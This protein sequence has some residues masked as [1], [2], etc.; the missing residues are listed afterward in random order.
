MK[1]TRREVLGSAGAMLVAPYF[2]FDARAAEA[3]RGGSLV[4]VSTQS[5]RHLKPAVQSGAATGV[6]G[7]QIFAS[8]LLFDADWKPHPYLAESWKAAEDGLSLT[9]NLVK[10]AKFHDGKPVTSDDV[11]FSIETIKAHHPFTTMFAPVSAV[12]TP[13]EHTAII[14]LAH[15][16]PALLLCLSGALCPII[17]KHIFG[18]GQDIMTHPANA[19]PVGSGPFKLQEFKPGQQ[20][21]LVKNPDFFLKDQPHLDKIIV[22]I[23]NDP[24]AIL[25]AV[26]NGE[27]DCYPFATASQ[28]IKRLQANDRLHVTDKGF[29]G[30]GAINWLA[31]NTKKAPLDNK[32]VRQAIGYSIDRNFITKALMRGVAR[33]QRSPIIESSPFFNPKIPAYDLDLDKAKA[34]LDQAGHKAGGDGTRF[35]LTCDYI[36]GAP[37]QQESVA[38]YLKSQLKKV[39]IDVDVRASPDF[40]TWA[41]RISNYDFDMTMDAV[42]NWGDPVIG[43]HRT[44]LSSNIRK[45]VIW[46][47]T[48]QYSN[49]KV[50]DLLAKA[51]LEMDAG[52]RKMLYDEFQMIVGDDLPIYWINA[53]PYHSG[54]DKRIKDFPE[55]IW[56]TMQPMDETYWTKA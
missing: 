52:K 30:L 43:V 40:P 42:Y 3:Q 25:L 16:H 38:Q 15:P 35:K 19:N 20:I 6:P 48:Q 11:K 23:S 41:K 9:L 29:E 54:Y 8:P 46:S 12:E 36:P 1:L 39:G 32:M 44:Y 2:T 55:S 26:E 7:A 17:P 27:A 5:P 14:R 56:G 28:D 4:L 37:E 31:F 50:D 13:D 33:P 10:N 18:D 34:L 53:L 45:G 21:V 51:G 49:P 24:N 47:N 22:T